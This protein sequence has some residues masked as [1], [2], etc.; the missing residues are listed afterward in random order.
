MR[1]EAQ[2]QKVTCLAEKIIP[3]TETDVFLDPNN[4]DCCFELPILADT[5][6]SD[7][8]KNDFTRFLRP[9]EPSILTVDLF[10]TKPSDPTFADIPL[11]D[12]I[13]GEFFG[14]DTSDPFHQDELGRVYAGYRVDWR[15]VLIAHGEGTYQ[16]RAD[17]LTI[18]GVPPS[19]F[20]FEY[21]VGNFTDLR[22]NG[23]IRIEFSNSFILGDRFDVK[24]RVF[25]P[26]NWTN[27]LRIHGFFG[28][29]N[30]DYDKTFTKFQNE[31]K[32]TIQDQQLEKY[33]MRIDH[34]PAIVH[35]FVKTEILQSDSI[36]ITDYNN[37]NPNKHTKTPVRNPNE[38]KPDYREDGTLLATVDV[39]FDS[40]FDNKLKKHC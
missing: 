1:G 22:A 12:D 36:E 2:T 11:V 25:F 15:L 34:A 31:S 38:Y 40:R 30:S 7:P 28:G 37:N 17:K 6:D 3:D 21:C 18:V 19:D 10:L 13:F 20:D 33:F 27:Q 16:L 26:L 4:I 29:D 9:Y 39:T 24:K 23:T 32:Q 14:Y 5:V 8:L 35:N